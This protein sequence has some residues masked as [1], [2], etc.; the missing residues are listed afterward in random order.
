MARSS[1]HSAFAF[2]DFDVITGPPSL[3]R[4]LPSP[5]G[6]PLPTEAIGKA[7]ETKTTGSPESTSARPSPR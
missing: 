1:L 5:A 4:R 6:G 7:G 3:P 2:S